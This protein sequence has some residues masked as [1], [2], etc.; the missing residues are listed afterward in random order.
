[1]F[2]WDSDESDESNADSDMSAPRR[3]KLN[4]K[5]G[6]AKVSQRRGKKSSYSSDESDDG[7]EDSKR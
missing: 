5:A 3:R 7:E 1:M 2:S 4:T 6:S